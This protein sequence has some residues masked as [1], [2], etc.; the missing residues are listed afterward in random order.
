VKKPSPS[1]AKIGQASAV[2]RMIMNASRARTSTPLVVT[3]ALNIGSASR[4]R[5]PPRSG[6]GR[7]IAAPASAPA[8]ATSRPRAGR[9]DARRTRV[10]RAGVRR[11]DPLDRRQHPL[12]EVRVERGVAQR[13][14]RLVAL[15]YRPAPELPQL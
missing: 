8:T 4:P 10:L 13:H 9:T 6:P 12:L 5:D 11:P 1:L 3:A 14:G 7:A 15:A 2:V